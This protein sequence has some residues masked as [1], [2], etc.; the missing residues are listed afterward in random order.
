MLEDVIIDAALDALDGQLFAERAG[1]ENQGNVEAEF[2][3]EI[4]D[5]D[6]RPIGK[7]IVGKDDVVTAVASGGCEF[8]ARAGKFRIDREAVAFQLAQA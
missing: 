6:A 7:A 1:D 3:R 8:G 4:Q 5:V 2:T